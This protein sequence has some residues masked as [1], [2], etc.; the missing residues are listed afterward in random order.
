MTY[1]LVGHAWYDPKRISYPV[2][3]NCSLIYMNN[4]FSQ[5]AIRMGCNYKEHLNY[6]SSLKKFTSI[7][8]N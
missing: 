7:G 3:K 2:C 1:K 4:P 5:W 8:K 6:N